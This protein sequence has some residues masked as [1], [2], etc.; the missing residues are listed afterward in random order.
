MYKGVSKSFRTESIKKHKLTTINTHWETTQRAMAAKLTR[1]T[2][3]IA[4]QVHLVAERCTIC[5]RLV[6]KLLDIPSYL[7]LRHHRLLLGIYKHIIHD[8]PI[9]RFSL[10]C[11]VESAILKNLKFFA[12]PLTKTVEENI[13]KRRR[14]YRLKSVDPITDRRKSLWPSTTPWRRMGLEIRH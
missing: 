13:L 4:T 6:R 5:R 7:Q 10:T 2:H 11:E 12:I 3:K 8:R 14:N 9:S 1:L